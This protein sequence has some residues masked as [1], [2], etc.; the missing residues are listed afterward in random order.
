MP[1]HGKK[2]EAAVALVDADNMYKPNEAIDLLK[3][4]AYVKLRLHHRAAHEAGYRPA[5][6]RPAGKSNS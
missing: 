1:T 5:A 3:K 4:T 2:Y 6:R